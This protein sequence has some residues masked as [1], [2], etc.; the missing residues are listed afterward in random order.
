MVD[1][2]D[3]L[4]IINP[5]V[6]HYCRLCVKDEH[7]YGDFTAGPVA[8]AGAKRGREDDKSDKEVD[9]RDAPDPEEPEGLDEEEIKKM[10]HGNF[11]LAQDDSKVTLDPCKFN[12]YNSFCTLYYSFSHIR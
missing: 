9:P 7:C 12:A 1:H 10:S 5:M 4:Y 2:Q 6:S 8:V 3:T 11:V